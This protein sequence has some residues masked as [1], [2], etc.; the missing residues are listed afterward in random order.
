MFFRRESL[1][2]FLPATRTF[3]LAALAPLSG[4]ADIKRD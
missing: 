4:V 3:G 2:P 1:K